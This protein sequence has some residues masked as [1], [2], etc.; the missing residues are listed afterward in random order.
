MF[1]DFMALYSGV[2]DA[3]NSGFLTPGHLAPSEGLLF[4][5]SII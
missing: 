4:D 1:R 3:A 5:Y 2:R